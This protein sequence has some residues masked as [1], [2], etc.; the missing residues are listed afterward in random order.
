M[1]IAT[2]V[3]T[4]GN[5]LFLT[6]AVLFYTRMLHLPPHQVG[7]GL[8]LA[9]LVALL[10]GVPAGHLADLR[11]AREVLM[12]LMV[13]LAAVMCVLPFVRGFP[14]FLAVMTGYAVLDRAGNAV[15]QGL[16]AGVFA[17]DERVRGR[18]YLRAVTNLGISGGSALAGV[19]IAIDSRAAYEALIVGD[20]ATYLLA[21]LAIRALPASGRRERTRGDSMLTAIRDTPFL[22]VTVLC[23]L[24][25]LQYSLLEVGLPLWVDRYTDAPRWTIAGL[26]LV[27]T[28]ACVLFQ[29]RAS[30]GATDLASSARL[31]LR[32]AAFVAASCLVFALSQGRAEGVA[33]VLLVLG[34]AVHVTGELFQSA[35]LVS[36]PLEKPVATDPGIT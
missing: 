35:P 20:A 19:A 10:V 1:A 28:I 9:G 36:S 2:L 14:G 13:G 26:Y 32:G 11:G 15:R 21:A 18:A 34:A 33:I 12:L 22:V 23:G 8:T 25:A 24:M 4:F 27:N 30:A 17:A 5:G 31:N 3:N 29:V 16:I 6:A 7:L